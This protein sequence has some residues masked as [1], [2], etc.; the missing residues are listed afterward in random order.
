MEK[1]EKTNIR[2]MIN[3]ELKKNFIN[4]PL[5]EKCYG[6]GEDSFKRS[7][8]NSVSCSITY[9]LLKGRCVIAPEFD[10][11]YIAS[12]GEKCPDPETLHYDKY[13]V[14]PYAPNTLEKIA[15]ILMTAFEES[16]ENVIDAAKAVIARITE[17][18]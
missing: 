12:E 4:H 17:T 8:I 3:A 14:D 7:Y 13:A 16:R 10:Y 18:L 5:L 2:R 1:K 11:R 6:R 15:K 9:F